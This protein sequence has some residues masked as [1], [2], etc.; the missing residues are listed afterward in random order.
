[1]WIIACIEDTD[2]I[3]N[4][5]THL[6]VKADAPKATRRPNAGVDGHDQAIKLAEK[7]VDTA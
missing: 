7:A 5:L 3:E 1:M 6:A 2:V 4:I